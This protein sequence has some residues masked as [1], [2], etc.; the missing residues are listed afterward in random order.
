M[1]CSALFFY[2]FFK[3]RLDKV[4]EFWYNIRTIFQIISDLPKYRRIFLAREE[5]YCPICG[6]YDPKIIIGKHHCLQSALDE[7]DSEEEE[8]DP[9]PYDQQLGDG[10]G[11]VNPYGDSDY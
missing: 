5:H 9:L 4:K 6:E 3:K 11:A 7:I 2:I 10:F 1:V 8:E